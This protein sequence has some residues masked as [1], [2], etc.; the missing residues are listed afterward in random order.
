MMVRHSP[1]RASNRAGVFGWSAVMQ[2]EVYTSRAVAS[3][4]SE[5]YRISGG[6]ICVACVKPTRIPEW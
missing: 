6:Q 2:R 1:W 3:V 4:A 5:A